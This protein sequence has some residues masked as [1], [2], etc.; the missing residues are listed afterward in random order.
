MF[1]SVQMNKLVSWFTCHSHSLF[2]ALK[3]KVVARFRT[4][5]M[6]EI[7]AFH[8][9]H[10]KTSIVRLSPLARNFVELGVPMYDRQYL[11][12]RFEIMLVAVLYL[13]HSYVITSNNLMLAL[14]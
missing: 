5:H 10:V 9:I 3:T 2:V 11:N 7:D 14:T 4:W 13:P 8:H 6:I 1:A 12:T